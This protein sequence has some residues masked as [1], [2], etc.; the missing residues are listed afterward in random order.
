M[1]EAVPVTRIADM[2]AGIGQ[3][4]ISHR[5]RAGPENLLRRQ[6]ALLI[7]R[8]DVLEGKV[9]KHSNLV[10]RIHKTEANNGLRERMARWDSTH[11]ARMRG[12]FY[13]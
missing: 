8:L 2:A 12:V 10:E 6:V 1:Q 5:E 11:P 3:L 7:G 4:F 9:E 13:D